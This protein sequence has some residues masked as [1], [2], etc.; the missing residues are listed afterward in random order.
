M[1]KHLIVYSKGSRVLHWL[2]AFV[3][4]GMLAVS[5]FLDDFPEQYVDLAFTL[6]KS[7][8]ITVFFLM[9]VRVVWISIAGRPELPYDTPKWEHFL[10]RFV[11]YSF[12]I[13]L[14]VMPL[15]GWVMSVA[16]NEIP[17]YFGLFHFSLPGIEPDKN[18]AAFMNKTH[19]TIAWIIIGLLVLHV[20][21]AIKHH[22]INKDD[23]LRRMLP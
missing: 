12:Y 7:L 5:F 9:L 3:V 23:V 1:Q 10:S 14:I 21:G 20:A 2:I 18:L 17:Y 11:Q 15:S 8:G 16:A 19:K 22:F 6:H 4:I 13:L